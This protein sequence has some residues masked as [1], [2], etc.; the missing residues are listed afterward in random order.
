MFDGNTPPTEFALLLTITSINCITPFC[1]GADTIGAFPLPKRHKPTEGLLKATVKSSGELLVVC[2][3]KLH[4]NE[5]I[6]W[7]LFVWSWAYTIKALI[8][9]PVNWTFEL[10]A[11]VWPCN[12][13][14]VAVV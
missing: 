11:P 3:S 7:L 1:I 10:R 2:A 14:P 12:P 6:T 4:D 9:Q 5:K 13:L 8:L